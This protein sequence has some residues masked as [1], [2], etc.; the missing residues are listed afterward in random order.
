MGADAQV[1]R[2]DQ[3]SP[4]QLEHVDLLVVGSPTQGGRPTKPVQ[5]FLEG[6]PEATVKGLKVASFDTRYAGRF[7]K[8]FGFAADRIAQSLVSKG[9]SLVSPP[10]PF[11]VMGKK[12]PVKDGELERASDWG[13]K[14]IG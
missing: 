9:G 12:G 2:A 4:T 7:V 3:M 11:I 8:V 13:R 10:E 1:A 6:L 14:I 5:D